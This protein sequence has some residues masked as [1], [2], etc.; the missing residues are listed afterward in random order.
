MIKKIV[1]FIANIFIG[2]ILISTIIY[3]GIM[4][5]SIIIKLFIH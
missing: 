5:L 4:F 1:N 3:L 2:F